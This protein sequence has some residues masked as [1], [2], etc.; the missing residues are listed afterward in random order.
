[1]KKIHVPVFLEEVI[2]SLEISQEDAFFEGTVGFSGHAFPICEKLFE[3]ASNSAIYVGVDRDLDAFSYSQNSLKQFN[4]AFLHRTTFDHLSELKTHHNLSGF[5]KVFLDLGVS[6][7]QLDTADRGFSYTH[8]GPLDMR[9]SQDSKCSAASILNEY[10][11]EALSRLFDL[12]ADLPSHRKLVDTILLFR[13]ERPFRETSDLVSVIKKSFY[14][15]N[16][17]KLYLRTC[18]QV[19][20][21]IRIEVN[22]EM[23]CLHRFLDQLNDCMAIKG[24]LAIIT[25]HSIED[26]IVKQFVKHQD[27]LTP[28][29]K[30]VR[31]YTYHQAKD[32]PRARS[33]KL[34][35]LERTH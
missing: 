6:S 32:N 19:F 9:M 20:Q 23:G 25:F 13:E 4:K 12:Y 21:S 7:F 8:L 31:Q 30:K 1:M 2:S 34:R 16:N 15:R 10:D 18:A 22:D 3:S 35:V 5:T 24:R 27:W 26:R 11:G 28:V 17:R 29:G 33:A 14:F